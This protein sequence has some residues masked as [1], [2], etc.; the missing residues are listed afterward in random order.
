MRPLR[1]ASA[2]GPR[3]DPA[4]SRIRYRLARLWLR[5]WVRAGLTVW[6]P[7]LVTG[8]AL[9]IALTHPANEARLRGAVADIRAAVEG[10]PEFQLTG[11]AVI[12]G[13]DALRAQVADVVGV[14]FP[15]SSLSLDLD[16]VRARVE[17]L[18]AVRSAQVTVSQ[19]GIL[20]L[21]IVERQP[22]ALWRDGAR[23]TL[24]D[25]EGHRLADIDTRPSRSDLPLL[26]GT[27]APEAVPEALAILRAADPVALRIRGL[28]RVGERRW[29]LVLDRGQRVLLPE[30]GAVAALERL[31]VQQRGEAI[32]DRDTPVI[33]LRDP[34]RP[35]LRLSAHALA[36]L[37][38]L[39][40][41][42]DAAP[43][44]WGAP[45]AEEDT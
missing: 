11:M 26:V 17:T 38:R 35:V 6:G 41:K 5:P 40:G 29:D 30:V 28:V 18:D 45:A 24:V 44:A 12:G 27:G 34:A 23:L 20:A 14:G 22:V 19:G 33:D 3:R 10:R 42:E 13:S 4:P 7:A 25:R 2:R 9:W 37:L 31:M 1:S 21:R 16:A 39:R 8:A 15:A 36:E 43:G 32:L